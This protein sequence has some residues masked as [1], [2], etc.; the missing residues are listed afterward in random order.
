MHGHLLQ[1]ASLSCRLARLPA[2]FAL[3]TAEHC[4]GLQGPHPRPCPVSSRTAA[5]NLGHQSLP[6]A[7]TVEEKSQTLRHRRHMNVTRGHT[8]ALWVGDTRE[9]SPPATQASPPGHAEPPW[10]SC[11]SA[12]RT[13]PVLTRLQAVTTRS[14]THVSRPVWA[15]R[16]VTT[17]SRGPSHHVTPRAPCTPSP[18]CE[19]CSGAGLHPCPHPAVC[20]ACS[21]GPTGL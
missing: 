11:T 3:G 21:A 1:E 5:Y 8:Y 2:A 6:S 9:R 10:P 4:V 14:P 17:P 7:I 18:H 15:S 20:P 13:S 16:R 12:P 19:G